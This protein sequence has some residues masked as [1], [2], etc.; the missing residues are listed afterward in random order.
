MGPRISAV[1]FN[2]PARAVRILKRPPLI[3][4]RLKLAKRGPNTADDP[5]QTLDWHGRLMVIFAESH[6]GSPFP[7]EHTLNRE[8]VALNGR[9]S[10]I[11]R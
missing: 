1:S 9:D 7:P 5:G 4:H 11:D 8:W 2:K 3:G 6:C 10:P